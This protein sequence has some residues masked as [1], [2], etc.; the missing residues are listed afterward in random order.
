MHYREAESLVVLKQQLQKLCPFRDTRSDGWIGDQ[1]HRLKISDHNPWVLDGKTGI[2]T[3]QD[4]D[5]DLNSANITM[6]QLVAAICRSQDDR[7]KYLIW[8]GRIT[9]IGSKLQRWKK[10]TGANA[11]TTHLHVSV[12]AE[13]R[14]YDN[15]R[16]W[17]LT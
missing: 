10:Y 4:I 5:A 2:V 12:K 14:Y 7:V 9:L 13:K 8:N 11:H 16:L 1:S 15:T 17:Q 6:P 3:A